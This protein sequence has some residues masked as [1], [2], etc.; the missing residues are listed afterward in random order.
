MRRL[1]CE[2]R[3]I[4]TNG[5]AKCACHTGFKLSGSSKCIDENECLDSTKR[6]QCDD[7]DLK[8]QNYYGGFFCAN[9]E[10]C[11]FDEMKRYHRD[12]CCKIDNDETCGQQGLVGYGSG[13]IIGGSDASR[14]QWPWL[15][16]IKYENNDG[17]GPRLCGGSLIS[18]QWVLTAAHCV[19]SV[20]KGDR[21][22]TCDG[23]L[24]M[25]GG[26]YNTGLSYSDEM[27]RVPLVPKKIV[28]HENY[29]GEGLFNDIAL[30]Q[31]EP[32]D[33]VS[34]DYVKPICLPKF[35]EPVAG[36]KCFI[37]GWGQTINDTQ[38]AVLQDAPI[39]I[40]DIDA[41]KDN[42]D[43]KE[44]LQSRVRVEDHICG[45]ESNLDQ[46]E[47]IYKDACQ[48]DSGGPLM[49]Q[50]CESCNWY[51][52]GVVSFGDDCGKWDGVYTKVSRY[53]DWIR[54]NML[55]PVL[56]KDKIEGISCQDCCE[57]IEISGD[58]L[59][60]DRQG[61]Y[62]IDFGIGNVAKRKVYKQLNLNQEDTNFL[63][64]L[65]NEQYNIWFVN[66]KVGEAS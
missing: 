57:F 27:H 49:C 41:C 23:C 60:K 29:K 24:E 16:W 54:R 59:Q 18:N 12:G 13:R 25:N 2:Q 43:V 19:I 52:A 47:F 63:W 48:G 14:G 10:S 8:C 28:V 6:A 31:I 53:E 55:L 44:H 42:Y 21:F 62:R 65:S 33:I 5:Q 46:I 37:A 9:K 26:V 4:K 38:S 15:V 35:E 30:V 51:V 22:K 17:L 7:L 56:K 40:S 58:S 66:K 20:S 1:K 34:S 61:I 32:V 64:F 36:T 39:T 45:K 3:C 50:R 11:G